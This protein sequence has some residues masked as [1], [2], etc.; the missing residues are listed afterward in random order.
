MALNENKTENDNVEG[1][2][3]LEN[4]MDS[5]HSPDSGTDMAPYERSDETHNTLSDRQSKY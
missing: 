3:K 4:E 5:P 1:A 2:D